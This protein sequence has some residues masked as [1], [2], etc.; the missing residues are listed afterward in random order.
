M[1]QKD[2]LL[3]EI[4]KIGILLQALFNKI[5]GK[6]VSY[7]IKSETQFE[8]EKGMLHGECGFDFDLFLSLKVSEIEQYISKYKGIN[9]SNIE[10]LADILKE[11]GMKTETAISKEYL[12]RA[13]KLYELCNSIDKTFSIDRENKISEITKI[14]R[15]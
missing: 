6:G 5:V 3:R 2:Y 4:E 7:A 1:E 11:M 15:E 8:E 12:E 13:L 9:C 14:N 10:L